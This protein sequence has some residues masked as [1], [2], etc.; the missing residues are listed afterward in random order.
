MRIAASSRRGT[1]YLLHQLIEIL[2][3]ATDRL[4]LNVQLMLH[5]ILDTRYSHS[6]CSISLE[7]SIGLESGGNHGGVGSTVCEVGVAFVDCRSH[8]F[9]ASSS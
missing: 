4:V 1:F 3:G 7:K 6:M 9:F 2:K 8:A 5:M